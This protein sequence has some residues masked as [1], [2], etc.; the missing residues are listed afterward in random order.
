MNVEITNG[1]DEVVDSFLV[2]DNVDITTKTSICGANIYDWNTRTIQF[3]FNG[4]PDCLV[5]ATVLDTV[6]IH[7]KVSIPVSEF[8]NE[9]KKSS[10]ISKVASFLNVDY[11]K[12]KVV[13]TEAVQG[14]LLADATGFGLV[15]D[16]VN[17]P[18]AGT[19]SDPATVFSNLNKLAEKLKQGLASNSV[20]ELETNTYEVTSYTSYVASDTNGS[21]YG[22]TTTAEESSNNSSDSDSTL[23]IVLGIVIGLVVIS[24]AIV[25]YCA[26]KRYSQKKDLIQLQNAEG[27]AS[28]DEG[29]E[30]VKQVGSDQ[31]QEKK[32]SNTVTPFQN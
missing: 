30:N 31:L 32:N 18:A 26:Y 17:K 20:P 5:R 23:A 4:A 8:F 16:L 29:R 24:I 2:A 25:A 19:T 9:T 28:V 3:A 14:R 22:S 21:I 27:N 15:I 12:I 13:G 6:R 1:K 7:I 10:F 11:S